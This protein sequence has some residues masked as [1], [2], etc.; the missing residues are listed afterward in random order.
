MDD[1]LLYP[2]EE[3]FPDGPEIAFHFAAGGAVVGFGVDEGD[4]THGAA[5][6]KQIGG[7]TWAIVHIE[8]LGDAVG[9]EGLLEDEGQDADGLGSGEGMAHHHAGVIIEDGAEDGF[10][11]AFLVEWRPGGRA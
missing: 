5:S 3:A 10:G 9:E 7:E 6:G 2:R 11:R 4:A 1:S 8:A